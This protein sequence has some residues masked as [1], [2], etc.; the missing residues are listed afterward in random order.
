MDSQRQ[1]AIVVSLSP[2]WVGFG[3]TLGKGK[4]ARLGTHLGFLGTLVTLTLGIIAF[5]LFPECRFMVL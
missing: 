3:Q 1:S 2:S 5:S 4:E